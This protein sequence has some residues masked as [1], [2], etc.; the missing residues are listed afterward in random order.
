MPSPIPSEED[1]Y[2]GKDDMEWK[3]NS[4][5][6]VEDK[7]PSLRAKRRKYTSRSSKGNV[8]IMKML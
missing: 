6:E 5:Q 8:N 3:P 2:D 7:R 1:N 4:Y